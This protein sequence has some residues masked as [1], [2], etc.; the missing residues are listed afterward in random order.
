MIENNIPNE[1]LKDL[2]TYVSFISRQSVTTI[3]AEDLARFCQNC[4]SGWKI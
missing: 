4:L 2:R 1:I 3:N